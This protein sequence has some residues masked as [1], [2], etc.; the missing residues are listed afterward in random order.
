MNFIIN[1]QENFPTNSSIQNIKTREKHHL[2]RS[3]AKLP[4][5]KKKSIFYAATKLFKSFPPTVTMLQNGQA[6]FRAA[7]T[8]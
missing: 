3:H 1:N 7:F 6:K 5:F 8:K 2:H 4:S